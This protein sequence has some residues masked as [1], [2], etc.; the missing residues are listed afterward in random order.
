MSDTVIVSI[1]ILVDL[2]DGVRLCDSE[3]QSRPDVWTVLEEVKAV[4]LS[5]PKGG[6]YCYMTS[7]PPLAF[8]NP[9]ETGGLKRDGN[10]GAEKKIA[11]TARSHPTYTRSS[12]RSDEIGSCRVNISAE[13]RGPKSRSCKT[14]L[15]VVGTFIHRVSDAVAPKADGS[16]RG[17][18]SDSSLFG[19][20][21]NPG[22]ALDRPWRFMRKD[23][24]ED[25]V[26]N[27]SFIA[28]YEW[29][30]HRPGNKSVKKQ[31]G[32][33]GKYS[34]T[35]FKTLKV[36]NLSDGM[37]P[38]S[39][40]KGRISTTLASGSLGSSTSI[41]LSAWS[42]SPLQRRWQP[43]TQEAHRWADTTDNQAAA[44]MG[45]P[46]AITAG[47]TTEQLDAYALNLRIQEITQ[48]SRMSNVVP[49][50]EYRCLSPAPQY[51]NFGRRVNTGG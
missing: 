46:T 50:D 26:G 5:E 43:P 22:K 6:G 23:V 16:H 35:D 28:G 45:L 51:D 29:R 49:A 17:D 30:E 40:F 18:A 21:S 8:D 3:G 7:I 20:W 32:N 44:M 41:R 2:A 24:V 10:R 4:N 1:R 9:Q 13:A 34:R 14:T 36:E 33:D 42:D 27:A 37:S 39:K 31:S 15:S 47:M 12:S 38:L 25:Y 48:K 19:D 11:T